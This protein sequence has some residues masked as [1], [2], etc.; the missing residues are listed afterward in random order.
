MMDKRL[1][2]SKFDIQDESFG[3]IFLY[4]CGDM[5]QLFLV[6]DRVS[7]K[8]SYNTHVRKCRKGFSAWK[9]VMRKIGPE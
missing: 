2:Q 8:P 4:L 5:A 7:F 6:R 9:T 1:R 3:G